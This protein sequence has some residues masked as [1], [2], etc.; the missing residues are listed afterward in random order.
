MARCEVGET[1][2]GIRALDHAV[3]LVEYLLSLFEEGLHGSD[4]LCLVT[5]VFVLCLEVLDVLWYS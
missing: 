2:F 4:E 1:F 3:C 5:I